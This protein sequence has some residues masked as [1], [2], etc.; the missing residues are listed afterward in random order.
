MT[1]AVERIS[2]SE[3]PTQTGHTWRYELASALVNTGDTVLDAACGIGYGSEILHRLAK[4]HTYFGVDKDGVDPQYLN[5]GWFTHADLD[6]W[7]PG[8]TFDVGICF[9]TLEHVADPARLAHTMMQATCS[10]IVSVPTVPTKHF[11]PYH[12]HDF[13]VDDIPRMF[14]GARLDQVLPQPEELS[15]IF[16]FRNG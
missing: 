2:A 11:N 10:I 5:H 6:T 1:G 12:L 13:T 9:E 7:S 3:V 15:H 8:F 4:P 14:A 16:I